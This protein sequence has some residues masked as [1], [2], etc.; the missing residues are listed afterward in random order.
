MT[1][2]ARIHGLN[3]LNGH[4]RVMIHRLREWYLETGE[5]VVINWTMGDLGTT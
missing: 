2:G 1:D 5:V 4:F 3:E